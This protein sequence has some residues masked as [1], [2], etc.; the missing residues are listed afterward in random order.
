M[1]EEAREKEWQQL[2]DWQVSCAHA[3]RALVATGSARGL[4]RPRT[5]MKTVYAAGSSP[6]T[7]TK[8]IRVAESKVDY[9]NRNFSQF[10][11][12]MVNIINFFCF[13][14][15]GKLQKKLQISITV[16]KKERG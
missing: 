1:A 16:M 13:P 15:C 11:G 9:I 7:P 6:V 8:I 12:I 4:G 3:D 5:Q 10:R 14:F 2:G